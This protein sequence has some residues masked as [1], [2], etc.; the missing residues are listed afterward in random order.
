MSVAGD[1]LVY[2]PEGPRKLSEMKPGDC[3]YSF[4]DYT[5]AE[6]KCVEVTGRGPKPVFRVTLEDGRSVLVAEDQLL[7]KV[8]DPKKKI[9]WA[10][11]WFDWAPLSDLKAGDTIIASRESPESIVQEPLID[12]EMARYIGYRDIGVAEYA[13][14]PFYDETL[15]ELLDIKSIEPAGEVEVYELTVEMDESFV[16]N[17][18]VLL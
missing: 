5:L 4:D 8:I 14:N 15:A 9:D 3:V 10:P 12:E 17:G 6:R 1:S 13:I 11:R 18:F 7:V 16:A 2:T